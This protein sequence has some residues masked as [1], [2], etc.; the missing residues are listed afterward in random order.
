MSETFKDYVTS[1]AF[2]LSLTR[3]MCSLLLCIGS[4]ANNYSPF[5]RH[6]V[7]TIRCLISRGLVEHVPRPLN[8][9]HTEINAH[10]SYKLTKAGE[11]VAELVRIAEI[12][13]LNSK[14]EAA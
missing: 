5:Y 1:T 14:Q 9:T 4:G 2:N 8:L 12:V 6:F 13:P 10:V 3:M 11:L 7:T